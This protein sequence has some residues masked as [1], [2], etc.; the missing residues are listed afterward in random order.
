M[1]TGLPRIP[2]VVAVLSLAFALLPAVDALHASSPSLREILPRGAQRGTD[3]ELVFSGERLGDAEEILFY[4]PGFTT[5]SFAVVDDKNVKA[6][7]SVAADCE[8]G[9]HVFRLRG[10]SGIAEARS[11][12]VGPY[13]TVQEV[14]PNTE[15]DAPQVVALNTTVEGIVT[16][17]DVDYYKVSAK[18]DQVLSVEVVGMRLGRIFDGNFLD[19]FVAILDANRFELAM[20]DDTPLLM[21]DGFASVVVPED[22]DYIVQVRDS[23]YEGNDLNRY[24]LHI[25]QFPRPTGIYPAGGRIGQEREFT[26]LGGATGTVVKKVTLPAAPVEKF[27]IF[28]EKDGQSSPSPNWVRVSAFDDVLETEPNNNRETATVGGELPFAFNGVIQEPG[29]EDW[30]KFTAKKGQRY[31]VQ[32]YARSIRSPLDSVVNVYN[33][34]GGRIEGNDDQGG[35]DSRFDWTAP[36][37][38]DYLVSITDHLRKGGPNFV[39]RIEIE[40]PTPS[41]EMSI[42]EFARADYQSRQMVY[43]P[44]GNRTALIVNVARKNIGGDVVFEAPNL[45]AGVTLKAETMP[46][47]VNQ[48]PI[49]FEAAP[50]AAVAGGLFD[51]SVRHVEKP[52]IR[53]PFRQALNFVIGNPNNTVYYSATVDKIAV[54][55]IEEVPFKIDIVPPSVPLVQ[56][57]TIN[58]KVVVE[59]KEGF[60]A[61]I[62]VRMLWNPP[63]IGGPGNVSIPE[64]QNEVVYTANA[65]GD[66]EPRTW[67]IVMMGESDAGQGQ[68][69]ASTALTPLT[70]ATPYVGTKIELAAVEQG[71]EGAVVCKLEQLK[72]FEGPAKIRLVGLPAKVEAPEKEFTKDMTEIAFPITTAVDTPNGQHKTLFC[73]IEI[74]E[75][76]QVI[77]HN[78]GQGGVLRVDP[79]PPPRKDAPPAPPE[80]KKEEPKVAE[81]APPKPLSRLEKLRLE[82][83]ERAAAG[84]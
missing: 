37:D 10:R 47:N 7:I 26:L 50:D 82:A 64:G 6:T 38:G 77:P 3:V 63:G 11:F 84:Q 65:N 33:K 54:A 80:P 76:G 67:N 28:D 60:K 23:S 44:K 52:E 35:P 27:G 30:F 43:V 78:A 48:F 22:G 16:N 8:L 1:K 19:P 83:K 2:S 53:G 40:A 71:K 70:I 29:D 14:E 17:E 49:V 74:P 57:G 58:L 72:P 59:R 68:I 75:S 36:E 55:A 42:P 73:Y 9:Q 61:P 15:F 46:G 45:P 31:T 66:A 18:K 81:A 20:A 79:P 21:Q 69:I 62:N 32:A 13:P 25:G 5:K 51:L 4:E 12:W 39:Y 41:L 24:R 56:G 34:D